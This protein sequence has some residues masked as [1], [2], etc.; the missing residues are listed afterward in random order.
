MVRVAREVAEENGW[1]KDGMKEALER[2][3][4]TLPTR[5]VSVTIPVDV[6]VIMTVPDVDSDEQAINYALEN[7][8]GVDFEI[9]ASEGYSLDEDQVE[10]IEFDTFD[11]AGHRSTAVVL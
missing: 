2:L 3:D 11:V 7:V 10:S 9:D 1:C 6:T 5:R 4:I 8:D